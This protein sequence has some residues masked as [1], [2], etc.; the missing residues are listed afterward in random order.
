VVAQDGGGFVEV[1]RHRWAAPIPTAAALS[2]SGR[3]LA[4]AV[5]AA[6]AAG[7]RLMVH[8]FLG[9]APA[10]TVPVE[11]GTVHELC[12]VD[13]GT[14]CVGQRDAKTGSRSWRQLRLADGS[15]VGE[16]LSEVPEQLR[17]PPH[18]PP[19]PAHLHQARTRN[20]LR[21][22]ARTAD[23]AILF[24]DDRAVWLGDA[25]GARPLTDGRCR[26]IAFTTSGRY[27]ALLTTASPQ[28]VAVDGDEPVRLPFRGD[29]VLAVCPGVA[30]DEFFFVT[31]DGV[32]LWNAS[33]NR[34][35][36]RSKALVDCKA[37]VA[38]AVSA[39]AATFAA[40]RDDRTVSVLNLATDALHTFACETRHLCW[41]DDG[42][43]LWTF[44]GDPEERG[45]EAV[46][47]WTPDGTLA[48][49]LPIG[50]NKGFSHREPKALHAT[51]SGVCVSYERFECCISDDVV[52][53]VDGFGAMLAVLDDGRV[54]RG[55]PTR[56][57]LRAAI[58]GDLHAAV[59]VDRGLG[60]VAVDA[61]AHH[62]AAVVGPDLVIWSLPRAR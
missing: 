23:R 13:D 17:L 60:A 26:A 41:N 50:G 20:R 39:K 22:A 15:W 38:T 56:L 19:E 12:F 14:V 30:G 4:F 5:G 47:A 42:T 18:L 35:V 59:D 6:P 53:R 7:S 51:S 10:R 46:R 1:R 34:E 40:S 62:L 36:R 9:A 33:A 8:E 57:A 28:V 52:S 24:D 43:L 29:R 32:V 55:T 45:G 21:V 2:P 11:G 31:C 37:T 44:H 58:D 27:V 61:Q 3:V 25:G 54:V 48:R 16:P 49:E